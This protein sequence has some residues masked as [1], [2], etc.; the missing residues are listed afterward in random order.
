MT[1]GFDYDSPWKEA[2][3]LYLHSFMRLC[4]PHVERVIDWSR[5]SQFLDK[6]LQQII[7]DADGGKQFVD[8]LVQVWL[9]DGSEGWLLLHIE[10]QHRPE[11]GFEARLFR[12]HYRIMD[13]YGKPVTTLAILADADPK[14]RP[15]YHEVITPGNRLRFDF[16]ACKLLDL[17]SDEK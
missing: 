13:V 12:Y 7:R 4:F 11:A 9:L 6:E 10:V 2:L 17:V 16:S 14:W 15:S 5:P 8:M 1:T 3:R